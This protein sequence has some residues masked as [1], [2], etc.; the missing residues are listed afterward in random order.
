MTTPRERHVIV[1]QRRNRKGEKLAVHYFRPQRGFKR[2]LAGTDPL[3]PAYQR[4]LAAAQDA[5]ALWLASGQPKANG[6]R[7]AK[8]S[9]VDDAGMAITK[10]ERGAAPIIEQSLAWLCR[11]FMASAQVKA[12]KPVTRGRFDDALRRLCSVPWP[13]AGPGAVVGDA[14][15]AS[16]RKEHMLKI[17]SHF[18][19]VPAAADYVIKATRAMYYWAEECGYSTTVNPAARMGSLWQGD[20]IPPMSYEEHER[21]CTYYPTGTKQRLAIDLILFSGVR[22]CDLH[23]LGP[24]HRRGGWLHWTEEK[25]KD[26]KALKRRGKGN[27]SREWKVHSELA[28]SISATPHGLRHF[29]VREDGQPYNSAARLSEAIRKW[30]KA[31]GV[32]KSAH[33]AR[34]LGAVVIADAG[35]DIVLVRDYLGHASFAEAEIYIRNRDRRRASQRAIELMDIVRAAKGVA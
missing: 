35:G 32:K 33:S 1:A 2:T 21:L 14:A 6:R 8:G 5:F 26:S 19:H 34:K 25:G 10:P 28:A 20:G 18:A 16:V 22:C 9:L 17:R 12:L 30:F 23:M 29:I 11:Q 13:K 31:A 27:K 3:T 4:S 15:F 24:Q 7:N